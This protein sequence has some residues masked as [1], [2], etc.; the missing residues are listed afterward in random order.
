MSDESMDYPGLLSFKLEPKDFMEDA[1]SDDIT[2]DN[3]DAD[4]SYAS[5]EIKALKQRLAEV[6]AENQH[7][8]IQ[9]AAVADAHTRIA[10]LEAENQKLHQ[11]VEVAAKGIVRLTERKDQL[12]VAVRELRDAY[13]ND[14]EDMALGKWRDHVYGKIEK[15]IR[16]LEEQP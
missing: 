12:E 9:H 14:Y 10:Q 2:Y 3:T 8:K 6:E 1:M 5:Q 15:I 7:L 11:S 4:L 13:R 16:L